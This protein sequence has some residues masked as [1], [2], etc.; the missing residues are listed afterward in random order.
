MKKT[1]KKMMILS[2]IGII[3]VV[4]GHTGSAV[5]LMDNYFSYYSFHMALFV[6]IS[7]YFY[8]KEN[9]DNLLKNGYLI[10]KVK[11]L[12][13]PYFIWN[14]VYG[15]IINIVRYFGIV[16]YGN[17]LSFKT[18]FI[19]PWTNG[20]Q[21]VLNIA[22]WFMLALFIVNVVYVLLRKYLGKVFNDYVFLILLLLSIISIKNSPSDNALLFILYRTLFFLFFYHFGYFYKEKLENK[23]KINTTIYLVVLILIQL[24]VLKFDKNIYYEVI[25]MKFNCK[26]CVTPIITSITG[27]LFWLKISDIL[28]PALK[29]S[30]LVNYIGNNTYDIMLHH[31][32]W[33]FVLNTTIYVLSG[34]FE[35]SGFNIDKYQSTIY[36][37]Y[38]ADVQALGILYTMFAIAMPLIVKYTV[39][40]FKFK[41]EK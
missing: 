22:S 33:I 19:D 41:K 35:L 38:T 5:H 23:F 31:L 18:L 13:I 7:G 26:L 14:I 8:K 32:F 40:K 37:T 1:N 6:F 30:K 25:F 24:I 29:D 36:Y 12:L 2:C 11:R 4:L 10:K 20:S 27:I 15:I 39:S 16:K 28:V 17:P 21:F 3:L 34:L 9:E